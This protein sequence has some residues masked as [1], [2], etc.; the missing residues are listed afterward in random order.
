M[1]CT[2][3]VLRTRHLLLLYLMVAAAVV[4]AVGWFK[5]VRLEVPLK[6]AD[7]SGTPAPRPDRGGQ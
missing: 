5:M 1:G 2:A 4:L 6:R 7:N 3:I